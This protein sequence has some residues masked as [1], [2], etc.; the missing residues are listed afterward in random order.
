MKFF[1]HEM[2]GNCNIL[3]KT[4]AIPERKNTGGTEV[5]SLMGDVSEEPVRGVSPLRGAHQKEFASQ[6]PQFRLF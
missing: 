1:K 3:S 4:L 2:L 6:F 5:E